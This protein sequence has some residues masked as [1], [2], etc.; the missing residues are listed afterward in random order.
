LCLELI[1]KPTCALPCAVS[2][3]PNR[4]AHSA[5]YRDVSD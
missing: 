5:L 4:Y 1:T 3:A 2:P